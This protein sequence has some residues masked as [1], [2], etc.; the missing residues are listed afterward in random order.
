MS[1]K[2]LLTGMGMGLALGQGLFAYQSANAFLQEADSTL[3]MKQLTKLIPKDRAVDAAKLAQ[4]ED[5]DVAGP[6]LISDRNLRMMRRSGLVGTEFGKLMEA[7][8]AECDRLPEAERAEAVA[9]W[10]GLWLDKS[11]AYVRYVKSLKPVWSFDFS[12]TLDYSSNASLVDPDTTSPVLSGDDDVGFGLDG[13]VKYRPTRNIEKKLGWGYEVQLNGTTQMQASE[14][15]LEVDNWALDNTFDI[16]SPFKGV[17]KISLGWN[18]LRSYSQAPNLERMEYER[19]AFKVAGSSVLMPMKGYFSA[20]YHT[21]SVQLRLKNQFPA[22]GGTGVDYDTLVLRYGAT[23]LRSGDGIPFQAYS[24]GLSNEDESANTGNSDYNV[25]MLTAN[26]SRS[27][28]DIVARYALNWDSGLS[29]RIK[30]AS[31][32]EEQFMV[33]TGIRAVWNAHAS[34]S[35]TVSYLNK[36][37]TNASDVDQFR[38]AWT[39]VLTTF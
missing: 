12:E 14:K 10:R 39:N 15:A 2:R 30:D 4:E 3:T 37:K 13:T 6:F 19:H 33:N 27:L 18:F 20:Y 24:I 26:Y 31:T 28:S 11:S 16:D 5:M 34:S 35:L 23:F 21:G 29:F 1:L 9:A 7:Y 8:Q 17:R 36:N 22:T 32:D 38:V 25:W